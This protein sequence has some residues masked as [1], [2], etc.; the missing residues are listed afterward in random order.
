M[1]ALP[2]RSS[3]VSVLALSLMLA[4]CGGGGGVD[5]TPNPTPTPTPGPSYSTIDSLTGPQA[6]RAASLAITI[7]PIAPIASQDRQ[8]TVRSLADGIAVDLVDDTVKLTAPDGSTST[9]DLGNIDYEDTTA[10]RTA[11][12]AF[13]QFGRPT[14]QL[15][16]PNLHIGG[17]PL[18][19]LRGGTWTYF[20]YSDATPQSGITALSQEAGVFGV[21]TL[22]SDVPT[23]GTASYTTAVDGNLVVRNEGSPT[24]LNRVFTLAEGGTT[25]TL[26]ANFATGAITTNIDLRGVELIRPLNG[27]KAV[28]TGSP[29]SFAPLNGT[30]TLSSSKPSFSGT[31]ANTTKGAFSG[32]FFGPQAV[33]FGYNF[34]AEKPEYTAFGLVGGIKTVAG[35]EGFSAALTSLTRD[36]R[37]FATFSNSRNYLKDSAGNFVSY[38]D[39]DDAPDDGR[40]ILSYNAQNDSYTL[41][42]APSSAIAAN[43]A[44]LG[45]FG[46]GQLSG[47]QP[48]AHFNTYSK[49]VAGGTLQLQLY[50]VGSQNGEI[51]LTYT[52]IG[53]LTFSRPVTGSSNQQVFEDWFTYALPLSGG[54]GVQVPTSGTGTY[55]GVIY[56]TAV[57]TE[58]NGVALAGKLYDVKGTSR[59]VFDFA[60]LR[61]NGT[62]D[63]ILVS[64]SGAA[65]EALA[66]FTF[67]NGGLR[68]QAWFGDHANSFESD[69][70]SSIP[71]SPGAATGWLRGALYGPNA[72]EFGAIFNL[73]TNASFGK[74]HIGGVTVGKKEP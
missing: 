58:P 61:F 37:G 27:T 39:D 43:I 44:A 65:N 36:V 15:V 23:T 17:R 5:S 45:S 26:Q 66:Q 59:F 21:P 2:G 35:Q 12:R 9:F 19:Y 48:D 3:A 13:D 7:A 22:A 18:D 24:A 47:T 46:S 33:E 28:P 54:G 32:A 20:R 1:R 63:P 38:E 62:L 55:N 10:A 11:Y 69:L 16:V 52:S 56:G 31:F 51:A 42:Q 29:V 40:L 8:I 6:L 73:N 67:Q 64:R 34:Y 49:S 71:T 41:R 25:A 14:A 57:P 4:A 53:H 60:T 70:F 68:T 74:V 30:G 50:K 72:T